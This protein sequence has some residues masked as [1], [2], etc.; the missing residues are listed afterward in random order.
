MKKFDEKALI[1]RIKLIR[2]KF[3]GQRGKSSFARALDISPSTYNYYENDRIPPIDLLLKMAQITDCD[4]D[5]LLTGKE[6]KNDFSGPN[7]GLL[8]MVD[9]LLNSDPGLAQPVNA[10]IQLLG[11]KNGIE[12]RI[13]S[14][15]SIENRDKR[16]W[17]P[18]LGRTAAGIIYCWQDEIKP[19]SK[20]A[21]T[22]LNELVQKYIGKPVHDSSSAKMSIDL[23]KTNISESKAELIQVNADSDEQIV[24]FIQSSDIL[25]KFPDAF[26]LR[27]DGDSMSPRVNDS[28]IIITSPSIPA[29][30]G[31]IAVAKIADQIGVTCKLI[32]FSDK[33]VHLIPINERYE[34]RIIDKNDLTWALAVICHISL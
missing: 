4:L 3:A 18:V 28:D 13:K 25:G 31:D 2:T 34:T 29:Q 19:D 32:R 7:S 26:A 1:Q 30:Q 15:F 21:V 8:K 12:N 11:Q 9:G 33:H 5:W 16:S 14:G 20:Q 27:V 17:I 24:E 23:N 10:F 22:Q 6:Q